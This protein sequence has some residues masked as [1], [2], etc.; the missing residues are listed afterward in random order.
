MT[1]S[2]RPS[3][4]CLHWALSCASVGGFWPLAGAGWDLRLAAAHLAKVGASGT[5]TAP[6]VGF[7]EWA[8]TVSQWPN[9]WVVT[10]VPS[11]LATAL[12]GTLLPPHAETAMAAMKKAPSARM[13]RPIRCTTRARVAPALGRGGRFWEVL[14]AV[15]DLPVPSGA[16]PARTTAGKRREA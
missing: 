4:S 10:S 5:L 2:R 8:A 9:C 12:P 7:C 15:G 16:P 6:P 13:R 14:G 11:T 3:Y 1:W